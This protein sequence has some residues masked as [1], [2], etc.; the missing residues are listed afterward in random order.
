MPV[1]QGVPRML[2]AALPPSTLR[3]GALCSPRPDLGFSGLL[4][5]RPPAIQCDDPVSALPWRPLAARH[6]AAAAIGCP[7]AAATPTSP[8]GVLVV[9][10]RWLRCQAV[11]APL[12][13]NFRR[14]PP[15]GSSGGCSLDAHLSIHVSDG[16]QRSP[17]HEAWMHSRWEPALGA[18]SRRVYEAPGLTGSL[19][20]RS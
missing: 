6:L 14:A 8:I 19:L 1:L 11:G 7:A 12:S 3:V 10:S 18:A 4:G 17:S 16:A 2:A 20:F 5:G 15:V 9:A 13:P